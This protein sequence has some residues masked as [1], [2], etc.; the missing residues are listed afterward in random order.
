LCYVGEM[1]RLVAFI[2][3]VFFG[4]R[5][6]LFVLVFVACAPL[7]ALM[8][9]TAWEDRRRAMATW[10]QRV[11]NLSQIAR[12]EEQEVA[13]STRQLLLAISE[14]AAVRSMNPR[15]AKRSLEDLYNSYK[16]YAN[17]GLAGTN[18]EVI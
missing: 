8:L 17:F 11:K 3:V 1:R 16:R 12:R 6:R 4:L 18:G 7:V 13:D 14:S 10:R 15:R 5:F 9:H 2:H